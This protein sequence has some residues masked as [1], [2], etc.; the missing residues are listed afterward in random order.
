MKYAA[1]FRSIA[2][3]ALQGK[4]ALAVI[5]GV[6]ASLLG[7]VA[8]GS[9][10]IKFDISGNGASINLQIAGQQIYSSGTGWNEHLTSLF[11]GGATIAV[12]MALTMA[13]A[14]FILGSVIEVGYCQFNLD[15]VD[16]KEEPQIGTLFGYFPHWSTAAVARVLQFIYV[17]LWS[18]LLVI[19]G[20]IAS[21]SYAMTGYIMAEHPEMT[22]SEAIA[23]SKRIMRGNRFR[24]FCLQF[25]F[26]GWDLLCML[27]FGIGYLWL[28]PYRQAAE[29]A[30]YR[31]ISSTACSTA[32]DDPP[33]WEN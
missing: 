2:R 7:A 1:D 12:I 21:F 11:I 16:R 30:F 29:A 20:I 28:N 25:S 6:L 22:A 9:P 26:V 8:S 15:L 18:L 10:E 23:Q 33:A 14:Y 4:W 13:V 31:E 27:T 5:A 17:L 24:L 32:S 3:N 19:P